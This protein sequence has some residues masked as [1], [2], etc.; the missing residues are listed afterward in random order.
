MVP[1]SFSL[2]ITSK[3]DL[4]RRKMDHAIVSPS[5]TATETHNQVSMLEQVEHFQRSQSYSSSTSSSR[6]DVDSVESSST[7]PESPFDNTPLE[8]PVTESRGFLT[9]IPVTEN[10]LPV[11]AVLGVGYVGLHLVTAFSQHY[12]V[13]AF[14]VNK[15]RLEVVKSQLSELSNISLTSDPSLLDAATHFLVAVPTPLLPHTTTIDTSIIRNAL[16]TVCRHIRPGATVVIESS[17]SVGMTRSL[18]T[19]MVHTYGLYA[20]MSPEVRYASHAKLHS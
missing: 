15:G 12:K 18:L 4:V 11:V 9:H 7:H 16:D 6:S 17:V 10:D 13:I 14:D 20:G 3:L 5:A 8:S 1:S 19:D 2:A